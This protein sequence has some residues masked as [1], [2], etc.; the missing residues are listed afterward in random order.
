MS[1][2][3]VRKQHGG[4][5]WWCHWLLCGSQ[6]TW[7][8]KKP[9]SLS[10]DAPEMGA[11]DRIHLF[12]F[13]RCVSQW[14]GAKHKANLDKR[15]EVVAAESLYLFSDMVLQRF[16]VLPKRNTEEA[17]FFSPEKFYWHCSSQICRTWFIRWE[18]DVKILSSFGTN[19][20]FR[21]FHSHISY[22]WKEEEVWKIVN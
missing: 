19:K 4:R 1:G 16:T 12:N 5:F 20:I 15:F 14:F 18:I 2:Q 21:L 6:L 3:E 8:T 9:L 7:G 22:L 11:A 10:K 13:R 17:S